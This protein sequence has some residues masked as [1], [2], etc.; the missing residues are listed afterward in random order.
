MKG[1]KIII[2]G[3]GMWG[4]MGCL[5]GQG[6]SSTMWA[7]EERLFQDPDYAGDMAQMDQQL[8]R[9]QMHAAGTSSRQGDSSLLQIPVV[10]HILSANSSNFLANTRVFSALDK[11]NEAF[12]KKGFYNQGASADMHIQFCM[13]AI[14]PDGLP[15]NGINR[16]S[17]PFARVLSPEKNNELKETFNWDPSSYLNIYVVNEIRFSTNGVDT[18][19]VNSIATFPVD[20]GKI[21]DGITIRGNFIGNVSYPE[22]AAQL[23]KEVGHYLGLFSTFYE[24]C[25][26]D[27]CM[28]Q[29]DRVCDTRPDNNAVVN[30][31]CFPNNN[32][33]TDAH[34]SRKINPFVLDSF[35]MNHLF[36][37]QN[38]LSCLYAFTDGQR[39][40][41]RAALKYFRG[42][43]QQSRA[44]MTPEP[45]DAGLSQLD[46]PSLIH[47]QEMVSPRVELINY[48][49]VPLTEVKIKYQLD[50]DSIYTLQW[51]GNLKYTE[52]EFCSL[53]SIPAAF[54][55][56]QLTVYTDSPNLFA[57]GQPS[58]DTV[59]LGF[60]RP[61]PLAKPFLIDF[62]E[63][64]PD[65]WAIDNPQG[66][67]WERV[68]KGCNPNLG[69]AYCLTLNNQD[70]YETGYAD[71]FISP[72]IDLTQLQQSLLSFDIAYGF[73]PSVS[74]G[75][76]TLS[77]LISL[78]CGQ[79]FFSVPLFSRS[80]S[81]LATQIISTD[82]V[83]LW[84]PQRCEDW[85]TIS[86][87]IDLFTGRHAMIKFVYS[88]S[89]NGFPIYLDNI[90]IDAFPT[91]PV[92]EDLSHSADIQVYP[93]PSSGDF[94]VNIQ[95]AQPQTGQ[96]EIWNSV[97]QKIHTQP[98]SIDPNAAP[99]SIHLSPNLAGLFFLK[100][101]LSTG[102]LVKKIVIGQ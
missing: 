46:S 87:N 74:Q 31:G 57:D 14:A 19:D 13:A 52:R 102:I 49:L 82:T 86:V 79:T 38:D 20:A 78:D 24:G 93:N 50:Q 97:G 92:V 72:P 80:G 100:A 53:P 11:L 10:F 94:F 85:K 71:A 77:A 30:E 75:T 54:G 32:C 56:H 3:V 27:D 1:I 23:V 66:E 6:A 7:H 47:C 70:F 64:I 67:T 12:R 5:F 16:I 29:G 91:L 98:I 41:A 22:N 95:T 37:D 21:S 8:M 28:L 35:D 99:L 81:N 44:C 63:D 4:L 48:G 69:N 58:N 34:D 59:R 42:S 2:I 101:H 43:L 89:Q 60:T 51:A 55:F 83:D 17:S 84:Q 36:M 65:K 15:T 26:N 61:I 96:L 68:K 88:K 45:Y 25:A 40:R 9:L 73:D 90:R 39:A 33:L 18:F 76:D 62:E